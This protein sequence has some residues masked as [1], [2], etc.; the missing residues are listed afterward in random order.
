M[1]SSG[2]LIRRQFPTNRECCLLAES[3]RSAAGAESKVARSW[4][5]RKHAFR[6]FVRGQEGRDPCGHST[7][8]GGADCG[9]W[10]SQH[11][12][13]SPGE[14]FPAMARWRNANSENRL[15]TATLA[16]CGPALFA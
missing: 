14:R 12:M 16:R 10:L 7:A 6:H 3:L 13:L 4:H 9:L 5:P 2:Q 11:R 8:N 1:A 15:R